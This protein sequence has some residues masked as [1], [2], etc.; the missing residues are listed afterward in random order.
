MFPNLMT[1]PLK[2]LKFCP[3]FKNVLFLFSPSLATSQS[4]TPDIIGEKNMSCTIKESYFGMIIP[5]QL[6]I[7]KI[8][9]GQIFITKLDMD[10]I[11]MH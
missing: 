8:I 1:F 10:N 6:K 5:Y 7:P 2:K 11:D 3:T 9:S 4:G